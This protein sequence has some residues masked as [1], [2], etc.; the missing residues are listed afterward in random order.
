MKKEAKPVKDRISQDQLYNMLVSRELSWQAIIYDLIKTEQLNPWD[1]DIALLSKKFLE[2]VIQIQELE[3]HAFFVSSKVMLAAAILLR[4]KSEILRQNI[5]TIDEILFEPKNKGKIETVQP[6]QIITE[7]LNALEKEDLLIPRTPL[8]RSRK[9]TINELMTA[10]EK[11]INTEHRR[12]KKRLS[13][14]RARRELEFAIPRPLLNI[15]QKIRELW[16]VLRNIF[17]KEKKEKIMFSQ[18]ISQGTKEEKIG[19]FVP[20]V[21]LDHQNKVWIEQE[22]PF[23]DIDI[24]MKKELADQN[25]EPKIN[26]EP[27]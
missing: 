26:Q 15:P 4:M 21:F 12:I 3:E 17:K 24:W 25:K 8:P 19:T 13:T 11:A 5:R 1:I 18:L 27:N 20:L 10:L 2:K 9:V 23:S 7:E 16:G 6:L 22:K 14:S